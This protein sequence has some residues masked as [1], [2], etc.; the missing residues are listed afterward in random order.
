MLVDA[1]DT[2]GVEK[3]ENDPRTF[4][5]RELERLVF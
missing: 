1:R 2:R 5:A 4:A 3:I